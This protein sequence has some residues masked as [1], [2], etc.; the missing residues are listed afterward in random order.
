M[1]NKNNVIVVVG[2]AGYEGLQLVGVYS[3]KK[4]AIDGIKGLSLDDKK[5]FEQYAIS[6]YNLNSEYKGWN[7]IFDRDENGKYF[8]KFYECTKWGDVIEC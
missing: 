7:W 8:A 4:K 2:D 6:K 3:S 1:K 5:S